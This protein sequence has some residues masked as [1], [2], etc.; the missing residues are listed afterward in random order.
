MEREN[1]VA[2]IEEILKYHRLHRSKVGDLSKNDR[3]TASALHAT[4]LVLGTHEGYLHVI[5]FKGGILKSFRP[6]D[7]PINDISVDSSGQSIAC[8]S[9]NGSVVMYTLDLNEDKESV[10]HFSEPVKTV[11]IEDDNSKRDKSFII[12]TWARIFYSLFSS[13]SLAIG[14]HV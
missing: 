9:D 2:V 13:R 12:G 7:R 1:K 4:G 5:G 3:F 10:I 6:H 11:C 8:C 14:N